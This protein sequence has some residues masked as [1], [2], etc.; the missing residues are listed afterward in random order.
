[1]SAATLRPNTEFAAV[2]KFRFG[3]RAVTGDGET[4][5]VV[6]VVVDPGERTATH[7]GVRFGPFARAAYY[8]PVAKLADA[9]AAGIALTTTRDETKQ[10]YA[11][12][13]AGA[14]LSE[15]TNVTEGGKRLGRLTQLTINRDTRS[16]RHLV[17]HHGF[18]GEVLVAAADI[19]SVEARDITASADRDGTHPLTPYRPDAALEAE[20]RAAIENYTRLR[21][22]LEG[23]EIHV[24]DG[25]L[26]LKGYISSELN[27]GLAQDQLMGIRG[28]TEIHNE[29]IADSDLAAAVSRALAHDPRTAEERIGVYAELGVIH[30]RGNVHTPAAKNAAGQIATQVP[31][32]KAVHDE[33]QARLNASVVPTLAAITNGED[34]IPGG[35]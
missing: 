13:P 12:L 3:T 16:L 35:D 7:V 33:L 9:N 26:W 32:V 15:K 17:V 14:F 10:H 30:L 18:G 19:I 11:R 6:A 21:I 4:G 28:L 29:L 25:V 22:D 24:I 31:G 5:R 2:Y 20:V 8:V 34:H 23:I 27:R 1:M